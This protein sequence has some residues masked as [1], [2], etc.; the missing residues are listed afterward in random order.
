[1]AQHAKLLERRLTNAINA[2]GS[3]TKLLFEI[4]DDTLGVLGQVLVADGQLAAVKA[5]LRA[6]ADRLVAMPVGLV[7][8]L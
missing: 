5:A 2:S 3:V 6:E 1:M 4:S 7:I 8:D